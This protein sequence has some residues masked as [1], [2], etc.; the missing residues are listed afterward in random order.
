V[1]PLDDYELKPPPNT[2]AS[3]VNIPILEKFKRYLES[4]TGKRV[5]LVVKEIFNGE[6]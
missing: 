1:H 5:P 3:R 2:I 4:K 6:I